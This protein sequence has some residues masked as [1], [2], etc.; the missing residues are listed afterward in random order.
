MRVI[1][2]RNHQARA[3]GEPLYDIDPQTGATIEIFFADQALAKCFGMRSAGWLYWACEPGCWPPAE[4]RG[5]FAT[6]FSAYRAALG[7]RYR[8]FGK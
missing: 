1:R 8:V 3:G 6:K 4:P 7:G 2:D 5:P